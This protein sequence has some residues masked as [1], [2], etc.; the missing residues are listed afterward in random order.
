MKKSIL[1]LLVL[2]A[3]L[4]ACSSGST[5]PDGAGNGP[6][7]NEVR[8]DRSAMLAN[9]ADNIILPS[10]NAFLSSHANL[11]AAMQTFR[12]NPTLENLVGLR[13][14][15]RAS[16]KSW[17]RVDLFEIGPAEEVG[18]R[19]Q[20]N[21]YPADV[22]LIESHVAGGSY[23]LDLPSNRDSKG[24]PALDYLLN[25]L[26]ADDAEILQ[27]F[28]DEPAYAAYAADLIDDIG[29]RVSGV[30][31]VWNN[32]YRDSFVAADGATATASV[33]R[34]VNDF[35]FYYER[36]LRAGKLGI[37]LGVFTGTPAPETLESYYLEGLANELFLEGLDAVRDFF[38]GR[39]FGSTTQGESLASYL[40]A[41]NTVKGGEALDARINAQF[42][43][44]RTLVSGLGSFQSEIL[45][46][47]PPIDMLQ[48]YDEVQAAVPLLK[49]DMVSA[50]SISIDFVDADGD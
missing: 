29:A 32:G 49:V 6:G 35:I 28:M 45:M 13:E 2:A 18:L 31:S 23:D 46:N 39:H 10:Y 16:Y 24:F 17:Q 44:A 36:F 42:N 41:L 3:T 25:G 47:N 40:R 48:A 50:M 1:L 33:D 21:T 20:V 22:A 11:S 37:P 4:Y 9:W 34:Y 8:F 26:G 12:A 5:D 14:S 38:N 19:L 27:K 7:G 15:W 30:V 43:A